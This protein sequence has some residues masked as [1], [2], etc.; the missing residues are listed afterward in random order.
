MDDGGRKR[1]KKGIKYKTYSLMLRQMKYLKWGGGV[2]CV[3]TC[4]YETGGGGGGVLLAS[5]S[6]DC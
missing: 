2:V 3:I 5:E 1:E 6:I 4:L